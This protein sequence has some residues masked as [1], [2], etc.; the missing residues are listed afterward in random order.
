MQKNDGA[1]KLA[2]S[3]ECGSKETVGSLM[4]KI[5]DGVAGLD[6]LINMK[7]SD[8]LGTSFFHTK[9]HS[10]CEGKGYINV[11]DGED[12]F[13]QVRCEGCTARVA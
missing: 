5:T 13:Q 4:Q 1:T 6:R 12:D 8:M 10:A 11:A 7:P 3:C 2:V 9:P